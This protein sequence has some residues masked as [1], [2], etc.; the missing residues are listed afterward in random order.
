MIALLT[1]DS[2]LR[3]TYDW[4]KSGDWGHPE[5]MRSISS[6]EKWGK[7]VEELSRRGR[8]V[9]GPMEGGRD[10]ES[11]HEMEW[12]GWGIVVILENIGIWD[13]TRLGDRERRK[14]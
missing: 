11:H 14:H 4:R 3:V 12:V 8:A 1:W 6:K 10:W 13:G 5:I 9:L 7:W 2:R